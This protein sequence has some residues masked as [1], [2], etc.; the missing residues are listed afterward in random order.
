VVAIIEVLIGLYIAFIIG[1]NDA[2][3]ALG[4]AVGAKLMSYKRAVL[5][6]GIFVLIGCLN[7]YN[8]GHTMSSIVS[9]D[10]KLPLIIAGI[11]ITI[12]TSKKI[13]ISTHQ[14]IV[15]AL[16]G[17]NLNTADLNLFIK[18]VGSWIVSPILAG[19]LAYM[20]YKI[21]ER[22]DIPILKREY[23]LKYGLIFSGGLIA[24]N[25]G[26][27]DLPTVLGTISNELSIF[28]VGAIALWL[29]ALFFGKGVSETV[30]LKLVE[31]NPL[32]AFVAQL[33][34]GLA[35]FVFTQF[36]MPVS[37]TQ[38]II[39]GVVGVGLTKGIKTVSWRTLRN[40]VLGWIS[41]PTFAL[42]IGY[43]MQPHF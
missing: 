37:T 33:S 18:I 13:P 10:I 31:L 39:G 26:S 6:F 9:G 19:V 22:M 17:L 30:G 23:F 4:T 32:P 7:G 24:Y 11:I 29:G 40:V 14:V 41:A 28:V 21:F 35:V 27:N 15:S 36:G 25:L 20:I 5:L 12:L 2:A 1:A 34:A 38:A 8:V 3:N 42:V 16:V 43:L